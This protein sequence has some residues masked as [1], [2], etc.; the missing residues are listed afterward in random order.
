MGT[1]SAKSE[2]RSSGRAYAEVALWAADERAKAGF[3][4]ALDGEVQAHPFH[5]CGEF[6]R[7]IAHD[8]E[9]RQAALLG[10]VLGGVNRVGAPFDE[11]GQEAVAVVGE[12]DGFPGENAA[13]RAFSGAVVGA[14]EGDFVFAKLL[15][16]GS[17]V[18]R[19]DGPADE[20]RIGH[21]AELRVVDDLA[22]LR[23]RSDDFQVAALTERKQ[24]VARPPAG[25]D[26]ADGGAHAGV[27]LDKGDAAIE[28][29]AAENDVI[30]Q[31]GHV[32]VVFRVRGPG[33]GR[34]YNRASGQSKKA[35][36]GNHPCHLI[37][38]DAGLRRKVP[39]LGLVWN[40]WRQFSL[41]RAR[42]LRL[43]TRSRIRRGA[44]GRGH[45]WSDG[46]RRRRRLR[47][48]WGRRPACREFSGAARRGFWRAA[49]RCGHRGGREYCG[50]SEFR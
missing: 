11:E 20:A 27:F 14:R 22:L 46:G 44:W 13:V 5:G 16:D 12:V 40:L 45:L 38:L 29:V 31:S 8:F 15:G 34:R 17:D 1:D 9:I 3:V 21:G 41:S 35:P 25:M 33:D 10:S 24:R 47:L 48:P 7:I 4:A 42:R 32:F 18:R 28:I 50:A 26:S 6:V 39:L 43:A 19:M 30:E 23:V 2:V 49:F 36:A 37:I